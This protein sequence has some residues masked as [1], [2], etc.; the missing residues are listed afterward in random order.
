MQASNASWSRN[1][2]E[3]DYFLYP[4]SMP[5]SLHR[6]AQ[7]GSDVFVCVPL[8]LLC[9]RELRVL[10]SYGSPMSDT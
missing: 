4:R 10:D 3:N 8:S 6:C 2:A 9:L 7:M 5:D 1:V